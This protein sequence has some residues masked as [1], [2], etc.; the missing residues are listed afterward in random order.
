MSTRIG[1]G[2]RWRSGTRVSTTDTPLEHV[3]TAAIVRHAGVAR[4]EDPTERGQGGI[5]QGDCGGY[6]FLRVD[7]ILPGRSRGGTRDQGSPLVQVLPWHRPI[8][9]PTLVV[10]LRENPIMDRALI[11]P[12]EAC[13]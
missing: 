9:S 1:G 11:H 10:I 5:G 3:A 4:F 13:R 8:R 7:R 6:G 12:G 2:D